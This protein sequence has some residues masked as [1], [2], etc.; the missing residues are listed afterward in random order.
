ML[1]LW[2]KNRH[3]RLNLTLLENQSNVKEHFEELCI[4]TETSVG[5]DP[6]G[7]PAALLLAEFAPVADFDVVVRLN[8]VVDVLVWI[9]LKK[10]S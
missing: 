4:H 5:L 10:R 8:D 1:E 7:W 3:L 9:D 2:L 6:S